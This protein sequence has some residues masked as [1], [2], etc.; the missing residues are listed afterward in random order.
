MDQNHHNVIADDK[1][2]LYGHYKKV[3]SVIL[4]VVLG[5]S[6][7]SFLFLYNLKSTAA[8]PEF[9]KTMLKKTNVYDRLINEGIPSV[10]SE[11]TITDDVVTNYMA[12]K[13]II[14]IVKQSIPSTWVENETNIVIDKV[15]KVFSE[16]KS[17][18]SVVIDLDNM[19]TYL[20]QISDGVV[21]FEQIIPSC[22]ETESG[23]NSAKQLLGISIDCKSMNINL[24]QIKESLKKASTT[25]NELKDVNI[26]ITKQVNNSVDSI[27]TIKDYIHNLSFYTWLSLILLII[28][29]LLILLLDI[30]DL[31]S[32]IKYFAWPIL[33]A[34]LFSLIGS[35]IMQT[36]IINNL[37]NNLTFNLPQEMSSIIYDFAKSS[38]VQYFVQVKTISAILFVISTIAIIIVTI[39]TKKIGQVK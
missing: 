27:N 21:L 1:I 3:L 32:M 38:I 2:V 29:A 16:P 6:L 31:G 4:A 12:Q 20:S 7:M 14:Y 26:D 24:D 8:N 28:S 5:I 10:I 11:A 36:S 15:A 33:S 22:A 30:S 13:A 9:Y 23:N 39:K 35:L 19:S 18:P 17:T 25:I 37:A 34:S